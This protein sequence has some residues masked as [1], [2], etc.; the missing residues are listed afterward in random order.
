MER[1]RELDGVRAISILA[2]LAAHLLPLGPSQWGLN[3]VSGFL[4]MALFFCL[5]GFLITSLLLRDDRAAPFLFKRIA[6]IWPL[7]FVVASGAFLF[8]TVEADELARTILYT[9]NYTVNDG[10]GLSPFWSLCVEAHFYIS[11]ALL[12]AVF[13]K[14]ALY[15]LPVAAVS[16]T[17]WRLYTETFASVNTHL[18]I[19]EILSGCILALVITRYDWGSL[20]EQTKTRL[21]LLVYPAAALLLATC[22][23]PLMPLGILRPYAAAFL[24][25][26]CIVAPP[27]YASLILCSKP[28][29]F[30]A[31]IS[32]ALYAIHSLMRIGWFSEGEKWEVY[33]LKRPLTFALTFGLAWLSTETLEKYSNEWARR[34]AKKIWPP[35]KVTDAQASPVPV[36][37]VY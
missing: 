29:A 22:F 3:S 30:I 8:G 36:Q 37:Q 5:S 19:D 12:I 11:I 16:F 17:G 13:R 4:G 23:E 1:I 31:K 28:L 32:F 26:L 7:T 27:T 18:R 10:Q 9:R 20:S 21:S 15:L 24:V 34:M 6:R 2:V 35:R 25:G 14:S 33:L